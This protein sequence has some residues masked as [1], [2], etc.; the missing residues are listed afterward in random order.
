MNQ[1]LCSACS[2]YIDNLFSP[3]NYLP[4]NNVYNQHLTYN[5]KNLNSV[6]TW[7]LSSSSCELCQFILI[8]FKKKYFSYIGSLDSSQILEF[9]TN[10]F[11]PGFLKVH[12][13]GKEDKIKPRPNDEGEVGPR[14]GIYCIS[15]QTPLSQNHF[16]EDQNG[17][18]VCFSL[19]VDDGMWTFIS[20]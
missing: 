19:W 9:L 3:S 16:S 14:L 2:S 10:N 6:A 20:L 18:E 5:R 13:Y 15:I 1:W 7:I 17:F 12:I 4:Q 8:G 11:E